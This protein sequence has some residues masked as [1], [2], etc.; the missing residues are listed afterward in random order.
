MVEIYFKTTRLPA[1]YLVYVAITTLARVMIEVAGTEHQT[2]T[3]I[4]I[5]TGRILLLSFAVLALRFGSYTF[6]SNGL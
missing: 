4:L 2:S 6:P 3:D 5:I 1:Q